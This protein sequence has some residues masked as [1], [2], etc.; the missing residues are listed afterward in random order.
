MNR[1][2]ID[3]VTGLR[4]TRRSMGDGTLGGRVRNATPHA[5]GSARQV[6]ASR[7]VVPASATATGQQ[8]ATIRTFQTDGGLE[9]P[10]GSGWSEITYDEEIDDAGSLGLRGSDPEA[11]TF[12]ADQHG[13]YLARLVLDAD[14]GE[15]ID[16]QVRLLVNDEPVKGPGNEIGWTFAGPRISVAETVLLRRGDV[17]RWEIAYGDDGTT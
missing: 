7:V 1:S 5:R 13:T 16:A 2:P 10:S 17:A 14:G 11:G 9:V 15:F 12:V 8:R 3:I 6:A 4:N